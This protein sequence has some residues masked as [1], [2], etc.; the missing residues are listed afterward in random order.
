VEFSWH[1]QL[2]VRATVRELFDIVLTHG[3]TE[4]VLHLLSTLSSTVA[5]MSIRRLQD[6][7]RRETEP[8]CQC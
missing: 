3:R 7:A 4:E 2:R 6:A 1:E 5:D 8:P